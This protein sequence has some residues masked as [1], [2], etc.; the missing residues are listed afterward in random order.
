MRDVEFK[1]ANVLFGRVCDNL[2][3]CGKG[4]VD[5]HDEIEPE[6]LVKLYSCFDI[7]TPTGLQEKVWFD[8][9]LQLCWRGRENMKSMTR[10]TFAVATDASGRKFVYEVEDEA[11]KNHDAHENSFDTIGEG[12]PAQVPG[13]RCP[14][15]TFQ[16][17]IIKLHPDEKSWQSR[18]EKVLARV[19]N[20]VVL[21]CSCWRKGSAWAK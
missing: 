9:C 5:H 6:D 12:T 3:G 7:T 18:R 8:L 19:I 4:K 15:K 17:Y 10:E 16:D 21:Q 11:D 1:E 20:I 13:H 2:E 14:V